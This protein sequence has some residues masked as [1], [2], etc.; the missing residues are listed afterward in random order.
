MHLVVCVKQVPDA[1]EVKVDPVKGTLVR[2]GVPS[3]ANPFDLHALEMALRFKEK[4][5]AK[6][7]VLSMGPGQASE[8]IKRSISLGA[9]DGILLCDVAFAGSDTLATSYILSQAIREI[10]KKEKVDIVLTGKMAIDGD[11]AQVGPGIATRLGFSLLT[12]C[13]SLESLDLEK[14][15][16]RAKRQLEGG[17]EVLEATLPALLTVA[18]EA[19][20]VRYASLPDLI[21]SIRS[22]VR[23]W[24]KD[25][26]EL[27]VSQCGLKG[28]PTQVKKIFPPPPK[29]VT[30]EIMNAG[31]VEMDKIANTIA[32]AVTKAG[33]IE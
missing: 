21:A 14:N 9:D 3:I 13:L 12:Y 7:T 17:C 32:G 22:D 15:T 5:G 19:N 1:T 10:D 20:E 26:F 6:A 18:K 25:A 33:I 24:N 16:I 28:S 8:V 23:V 4:Y 29:D 30:P 11:T 31:E 27:D 2:Q